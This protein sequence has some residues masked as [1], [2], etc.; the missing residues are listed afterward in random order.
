MKNVIMLLVKTAV[1]VIA[2]LFLI[3]I[4]SCTPKSAIPAVDETEECLVFTAD[5]ITGISAT[6]YFFMVETIKF[7]APR[8]AVRVT[9]TDSC[10]IYTVR[11]M[12]TKPIGQYAD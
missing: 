4:S 10:V 8:R 1:I 12:Y 9:P 3:C 7:A 2:V 5:D 11:T 6:R